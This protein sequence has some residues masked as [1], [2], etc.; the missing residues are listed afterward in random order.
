MRHNSQKQQEKKNEI[1]INKITKEKS[2]QIKLKTTT[3]NYNIQ[4]KFIHFLI[5]F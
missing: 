2:K 4:T 1:R 5:L 3:I